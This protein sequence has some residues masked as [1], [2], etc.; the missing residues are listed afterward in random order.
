MFNL[1]DYQTPPLTFALEDIGKVA[2]Q[3]DPWTVTRILGYFLQEKYDEQP[4]LQEGAIYG[5]SFLGDVDDDDLPFY[6]FHALVSLG[7]RTESPG[8]KEA[9]KETFEDIICGTE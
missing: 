2:G 1:E 6:I 3:E 8:I 4:I 9:I 7:L 5:L